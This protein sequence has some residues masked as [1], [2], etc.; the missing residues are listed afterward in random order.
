MVLAA[1]AVILTEERNIRR[2]HRRKRRLRSGVFWPH[3][4]TT[5]GNMER[6]TCSGA[7]GGM[8]LA[9]NWIVHLYTLDEMSLVVV[10][11]KTNANKAEPTV[12]LT[13]HKKNSTTLILID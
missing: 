6:K 4:C 10:L 9:H 13:A 8:C 2:Q 5:H 7:C 3:A 12:L 11:S 1:M